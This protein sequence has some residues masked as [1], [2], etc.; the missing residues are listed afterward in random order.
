MIDRVV[1]MTSAAPTPIS[2]RSPISAAGVEVSAARPAPAAKTA[3]PATRT[4][5]RP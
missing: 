4:G 3:S 5:L 1:G 2:P